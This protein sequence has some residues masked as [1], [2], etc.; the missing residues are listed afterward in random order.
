MTTLQLIENKV[1]ELTQYELLVLLERV[2]HSLKTFSL[3]P[4]ESQFLDYK[5]SLEKSSRMIPLKI[6]NYEVTTKSKFSREEIYAD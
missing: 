3:P 4:E 2:V 6:Y 5:E 1:P